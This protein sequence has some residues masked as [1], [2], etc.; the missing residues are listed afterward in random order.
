MNHLPRTKR[1][2]SL[3]FGRTFLLELLTD[4]QYVNIIQWVG[5]DGKFKMLDPNEISRL[6]GERKNKKDM[7]YEHLS[8]A[9]RYYYEEEAKNP[10]LTKVDCER[11]AYKFIICIKDVMGGDPQKLSDIVNRKERQPRPRRHPNFVFSE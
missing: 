1:F 2:F 5:N 7:C 3:Y 8:R 11:H 10:I 6:W 4:P 9:L